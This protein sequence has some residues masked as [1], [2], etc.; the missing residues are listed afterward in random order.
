MRPG[1]GG[2]KERAA[3]RSVIVGDNEQ[4]VVFGAGGLRWLQAHR[5]AECRHN[6]KDFGSHSSWLMLNLSMIADLVL[7]KP[8][9]RQTAHRISRHK[10]Y[11]K[12]IR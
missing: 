9:I 8:A 4:N 7:P 6:E 3:V 10:M 5:R 12:V 2:V 11:A 1:V